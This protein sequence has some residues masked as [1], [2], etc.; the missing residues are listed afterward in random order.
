MNV[1]RVF[2]LSLLAGLAAQSGSVAGQ[3]VPDTRPHSGSISGHVVVDGKPGAGIGLLL[4][5]GDSPEGKPIAKAMAEGDGSYRFSEVRS[6]LYCLDVD[7]PDLVNGTSPIY[8]PM[9]WKVSVGNGQGVQGVDITL[10]R[11]GVISGRVVTRD[12]ITVPNEPVSLTSANSGLR[13]GRISLRGGPFATDSNGDFMLFGIPPGK[14]LISVGFDLARLRGDIWDKNDFS[15]PFGRIAQDHFYEETF[16]PG[17]TGKPLAQSIDVPLGSK[18]DGIE[19]I[20]GRPHS[21]Y[22][23]SGR[24]ID[25]RTGQVVPN[26]DLQVMQRVNQGF[27]GA[28]DGIWQRD[29]ADENGDFTISGLIPGRFFIAANFDEGPGDL[30]GRRLDFEIDDSNITGLQVKVEHGLMLEG[31][32]VAPGGDK[33]LA[34]KASHLILSASLRTEES[35]FVDSERSANIGED[36]SFRVSGLRRG[37]ADIAIL[38]T[39]SVSGFTLVRIEYPRPE[40]ESQ[41][42]VI[43]AQGWHCRIPIGNKDIK[44]VRVVLAYDDSSIKCHVAITGRLPVGM[45]LFAWISHSN[46]N[47]MVGLDANGDFT[48]ER[49]EPG[50]YEVEIGE[51]GKRFTG[52]KLVR[53]EKNAQ[54]SVSF[55]LDASRIEQ[56]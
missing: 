50:D 39:R 36:G 10:V 6:G 20:V 46:S 3:Q 29:K 19:I 4:F 30:Y 45:R 56:R 37:V 44:G 49:L 33:G 8:G 25:G 51:G 7:S 32:V 28:G 9:G 43:P 52:K 13:R 53:V 15:G 26:C 27:R 35:E 21:T 31:I 41:P 38:P 47:T 34:A 22:K 42:L 1:I 40:N 14:Y 11:G 17:V 54:V 12:G 24:V 2:I 55:V 5:G 18:V 23:A 48:L 16:Y